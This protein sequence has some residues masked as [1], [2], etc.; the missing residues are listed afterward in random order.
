MTLKLIIQAISHLEHQCTY[1]S[2]YCDN[3]AGKESDLQ[4]KIQ[5]IRGK[6]FQSLWKFLA[7][8]IESSMERKYR[9]GKG[10]KDLSYFNF[11]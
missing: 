11:A 2:M 3:R 5:D 1:L 8:I 7:R 10:K 9:L 6:D 4:T